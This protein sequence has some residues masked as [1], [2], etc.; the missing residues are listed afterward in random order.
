MNRK[1]P[2][3]MILVFGVLLVILLDGLL[4][5]AH[6]LIPHALHWTPPGW[7]PFV[8]ALAGGTGL[9][10]AFRP[11]SAPRPVKEVPVHQMR[12][13]NGRPMLPRRVRRAQARDARRS[14]GKEPS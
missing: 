4:G 1:R 2:F 5:N 12:R 9:G 11:P 8:L 14:G 6:S 3:W 10:I 7:W 13:K